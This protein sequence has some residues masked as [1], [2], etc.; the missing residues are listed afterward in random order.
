MPTFDFGFGPVPA[1]R[2]INPS[3]SIGGWVANSAYVSPTVFV[4]ETAKIFGE[5]RVYGNAQV[6]NN[7]QVYGNAQ[8]CDRAEISD[9]AK[10]CDNSYVRDNSRVFGRAKVF[11]DSCIYGFA[12]IYGK[13]KIQGFVSYNIRAE[14]VYI[15]KKYKITTNSFPFKGIS[16][17]YCN[18]P[19][20]DGC[21]LPALCF[22]VNLSN[23]KQLIM[24]D[25]LP[26]LYII[27]REL[28]HKMLFLPGGS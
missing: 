26:R 1:H 21:N 2:H 27:R 8:V 24:D 13:A 20:C 23:Y 17:G 10:V 6:Y 19:T 18:N 11:G 22:S 4:G 14:D 3:G 25:N 15:N 28:N 5:A 12:R 9:Y 16:I 7:A